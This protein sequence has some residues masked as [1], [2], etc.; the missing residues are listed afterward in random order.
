MSGSIGKFKISNVLRP[1]LALA[2]AQKI[3]VVLEATSPR[4]RDVYRH[5]G[6]EVVE[7]LRVGVEVVCR[8]G[9]FSDGGDGVVV[10]LMV[11]E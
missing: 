5:L 8:D 4:S 7:E 3:P 10:W 11:F 9:Y 6:F 2:A 1:I